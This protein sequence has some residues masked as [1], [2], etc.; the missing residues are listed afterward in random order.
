MHNYLFLSYSHLYTRTRIYI[1]INSANT[2]P[3]TPSSYPYTYTFFFLLLPI[4]TAEMEKKIREGKLIVVWCWR[5]NGCEK[6]SRRERFNPL[7]PKLN[8]LGKIV[9]VSVP[10]NYLIL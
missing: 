3:G 7:F 2:F 6:L 4:E 10:N 5:V 9:S 1:N 8:V